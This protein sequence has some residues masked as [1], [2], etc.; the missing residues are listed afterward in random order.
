LLDRAELEFFRRI[1]TLIDTNPVRHPK[2]FQR[3]C[4][5]DAAYS[6]ENKEAI[7]TSVLFENGSLLEEKSYGGEYTFP[8]HKGLFFLHEGPFVVAAV[9]KLE[10]KPEL[11]CFDA[12]GIAHPNFKGLASVCGMVLGIPSI[13]IAKNLLVGSPIPY[14]DGLDKLRFDGIDVGFVI[15]NENNK[16]EFWSPGYSISMLDLEEIISQTGESCRKALRLA[17]QTASKAIREIT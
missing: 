8:Y 5:V 11:V 14:K 15:A 16:K 6:T 4:G 10:A 13:G 1:Q 17:H 9:E 2:K 12:H 7:A 3:I